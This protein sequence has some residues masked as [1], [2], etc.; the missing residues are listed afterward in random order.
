MYIDKYKYIHH[1]YRKPVQKIQCLLHRLWK[2]CQNK[3]FPVYTCRDDLNM[4]FRL[5]P[6][7]T[8]TLRKYKRYFTK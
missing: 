2:I 7:H 5:T 8:I 1:I 4:N 6:Y 3:I